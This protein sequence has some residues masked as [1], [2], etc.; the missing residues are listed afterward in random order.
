MRLG[1]ERIAQS[2]NPRGANDEVDDDIVVESEFHARDLLFPAENKGVGSG[3]SSLFPRARRNSRLC[4]SPAGIE[5]TARAVEV[6]DQRCVILP[7][8]STIL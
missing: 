7:H 4:R 1:G 6:E 5:G 8:V 3:L 2:S